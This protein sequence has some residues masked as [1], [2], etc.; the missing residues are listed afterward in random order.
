MQK[1]KLGRSGL[2]VAPFG[3]GGNVFGWTADEKTS[4][5]LLDAF[6]GEGFS[7]VD[8]ADMYSNWVPGHQGGE[9]E[10]MIGNWLRKTGKRSS[11]VLATKVGHQMSPEKKGLK[12]EYILRSV[13]DSLRRLQTD[14]IDLYQSHVDDPSTPIEETLSAY[15]ILIKAGKVRAIGASNFT[16]DRLV[17][18]LRISREKGLPRYETLQPLYNLYDRDAYEKDLLR[19]CLK[20]EIG[21]I[22]YFSL[23]AGFLTGKYRTEADLEKSPR[24]A[25]GVNRYFNEK[26]L[27]LLGAMDKVAARHKANPTQVA[28]AWLLSRPTVAAPLASATS[29]AQ[30]QDIFAGVRLQLSAESLS[31][32]DEASRPESAL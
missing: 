12:R 24:G 5:A 16:A 8:T 22:N 18:S 6:V 25:R 32:L 1:R 30:L 27:K 21:V 20:E 7:L 17:E 9:S 4:F 19:V 2:E 14:H 10:T 3:F 28:I 29:L 31:E 15:D 11:I 13:E 23:G 26:G